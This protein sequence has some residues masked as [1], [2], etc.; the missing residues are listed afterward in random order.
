M[1]TSAAGHA[2]PIFQ[3]QLNAMLALL[4]KAEAH[5]KAREFPPD[6]FLTWRLAPDMLPFIDQ[7]QRASDIAMVC[8][9]RLLGQ[10][11]KDRPEAPKSLEQCRQYI[12]FALDSIA[13]VS[14]TLGDAN[15]P[16]SITIGGPGEHQ[17]VSA[18]EYM[19][20]VAL[21]HFFFHATITYGLLRQAGVAIG[22]ADYL[23]QK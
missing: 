16:A 7:I 17:V 9:A 13:S 20:H 18:D 19:R 8:S 15:I 2:I 22:K 10:S 5:A 6:S 12:L 14:S 21:P 23:G 11:V 1:Q 3:R 4:D